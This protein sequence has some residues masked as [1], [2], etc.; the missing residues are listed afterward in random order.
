MGAGET[1]STRGTWGPEPPDLGSPVS[2]W[3]AGARRSIPYAS[4]H[5]SNA[6]R[7]R[8]PPP[9]PPGGPT[10]RRPPEA[11]QCV[12]KRFFC[13]WRN[14][15]GKLLR[16]GRGKGSKKDLNPSP[17]PRQRPRISVS[18]VLQYK[19]P[20]PILQT[21]SRRNGTPE[22]HA[23]ASPTAHTNSL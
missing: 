22:R 5:R 23:R 3:G 6:S 14:T 1:L 9:A 4:R 10:K 13:P 19:K 2:W 16:E 15:V 12:S 11:N 8:A 17:S 7:K 18:S 21:P 20:G